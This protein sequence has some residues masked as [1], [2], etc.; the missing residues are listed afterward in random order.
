MVTAPNGP[1]VSKCGGE[2]SGGTSTST[3]EVSA[4]VPG[5]N[6]SHTSPSPLVDGGSNGVV[7]T[8]ATASSFEVMWVVVVATSSTPWRSVVCRRGGGGGE[9]AD[10]E[11]P[12][13]SGARV[14][15]S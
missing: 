11:A 14:R 9:S 8:C 13:G 4:E 1:V 3:C 5:G 15:D 6:A 10:N 12:K 2:R 7:S